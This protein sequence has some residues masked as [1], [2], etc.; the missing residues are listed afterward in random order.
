[1]RWSA[2]VIAV[3]P[4]HR[5]DLGGRIDKSLRR[6]ILIVGVL[7]IVVAGLLCAPH[8]WLLTSTERK[9][10]GSWARADSPTTTQV[11]IFASDRRVTGRVVGRSGATVGEVLG[12]KD[13]TWFVD[14][15]TV[16]IRRGRKG[17]PSLLELVS[18][19]DFRWEQWPIV[20][21]TDNTL[22]VGNESWSLRLVRT[23]DAGKY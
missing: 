2:T 19:N 8:R 14:G 4:R 13:E 15:Q 20:S 7:A 6:P 23:R 21:L 17:S 18:G 10:V 3:L 1:M 16:F 5:H 12:D 11:F 9:L 22:V